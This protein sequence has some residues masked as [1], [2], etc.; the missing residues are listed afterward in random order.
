[1]G[2]VERL[3]AGVAEGGGDYVRADL[4]GVGGCGAH[5]GL[6]CGVGDAAGAGDGVGSL[7]D[8]VGEQAGGA[9]AE[10]AFAY[11]KAERAAVGDGC[12]RAAAALGGGARQDFV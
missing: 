3:A 2:A 11:G 12:G 7:E 4:G 5:F 9:Q 10:V 6:H 1:M 8:F